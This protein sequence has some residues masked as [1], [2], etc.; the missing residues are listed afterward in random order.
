MLV[1]EAPAQ[2]IH[3]PQIYGRLRSHVHVSSPLVCL[4]HFYLDLVT[5]IDRPFHFLRGEDEQW[6]RGTIEY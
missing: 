4:R 3:Q 5:I 1:T 2:V 6:L